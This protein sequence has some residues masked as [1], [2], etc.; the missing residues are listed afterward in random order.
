MTDEERGSLLV[1][2]ERVGKEVQRLRTKIERYINDCN[3]T[4]AALKLVLS[5]GDFVPECLE[6]I[7]SG[8]LMDVP[9]TRD[10]LRW[11][12]RKAFR[13]DDVL[14]GIADVV[15]DWKNHLN[16]LSQLNDQLGKQP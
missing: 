5:H 9:V 8:F 13:P 10:N 4:A 3:N 6:R 15:N 7:D 12:E 2:K 16:T 14:T 11:E 1:K